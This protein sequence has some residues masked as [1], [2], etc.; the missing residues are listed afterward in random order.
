MNRFS[1]GAPSLGRATVVVL[2]LLTL[3]T[4]PV[5]AASRGGADRPFHG[6]LT[7]QVV[8]LFDWDHPTCPVTTVS[9]TWGTLG[10]LGRVTAHWSHCPPVVLPGYTNGHVEIVAANGDRLIGAYDDPDGD[11]P[12]TIPIVGGTGR[13]AHA[14]GTLVLDFEATGEWDEETDL[15][16][17]PWHFEGRL[18]G[19]I[20]Y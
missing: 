3:A 9:D 13:F 17:S 2:L 20:S 19:T 6:S 10:H 16:I 14:T 18:R 7:G 4:A 8:F 1:P 5:A 12:F 15:P 11:S